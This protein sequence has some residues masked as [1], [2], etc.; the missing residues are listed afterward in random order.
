MKLTNFGVDVFMLTYVFISLGHRYRNGIADNCQAVF[1]SNSLF[2][3]PTNGVQRFP[4]LYIFID[5]CDYLF[6][7]CH[8]TGYE[9]VF[10][11]GFEDHISLFIYFSK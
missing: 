8:P 6:D 9:V 3:I 1:Q 5:T 2:Y 10:H 11:W 7:Y 4:F